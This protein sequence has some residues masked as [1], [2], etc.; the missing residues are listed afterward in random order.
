MDYFQKINIKKTGFLVFLLVIAAA[1]LFIFNQYFYKN[2]QVIASEREELAVT[3]TIEAKSVTAAFKVPGKIQELHV[4]EG[5][6]VEL[7]GSLALL[8]SKE[9]QAKLTQAQAAREAAD[10]VANQAQ[11][12]VGAATEEVEAAI[13]YAES[14]VAQAEVGLKNAK[15]LYDRVVPLHENGVASDKELDE[16]ANNYE[17]AQKTLEEAEAGLAQAE[18][19][20][21]KVEV[22]EAA[23][24]A[25]LGQCKQADGAISE[26]QAYLDNILLTAPICGYITQ[27]FLEA[28]EMVNAG[29]PVF[30][31]TDLA[32]THVK[33]FISEKKIGRVHLGQEAEIRVDAFPD[34]VF[35]G[36]VVWINNA[37]EFAV[38]K[39]VDDQH[40]R[41]IRSFQV[42]IE[43]PNPDLVL[44]TGMTA[45]VKIL[46]GGE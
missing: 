36:K 19:A 33:V 7:G 15:Q 41:D 27:K 29:T 45:R 11:K 10:A 2:Q 18:S 46:E 30:E 26:A 28:G 14:K 3:G 16:A 6:R 42:K 5:D 13:Q 43:I 4:N 39:A 23:H 37:G 32:N 17:L 20:R 8:E 35:K 22:A 44:K 31:I 25:A 24:G 34:K 9:L 12:G 1:S 40:E 38:K 21:K